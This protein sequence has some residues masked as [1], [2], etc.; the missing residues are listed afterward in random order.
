MYTATSTTLLQ[1][2]ASCLHAALLLTL[3]HLLLHYLP[4]QSALECAAK[5]AAFRGRLAIGGRRGSTGGVLTGPIAEVLYL[6][7]QL[8]ETQGALLVS[9]AAGKRWRYTHKTVSI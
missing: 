3:L 7:Q 2:Q 8:K 5:A 6:Q 1:C 4:L 9:R